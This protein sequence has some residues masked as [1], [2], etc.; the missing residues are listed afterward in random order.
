MKDAKVIVLE[1]T[2]GVSLTKCKLKIGEKLYIVKTVG[3]PWNNP[4]DYIE[5]SRSIGGQ[6]VFNFKPKDLKL[7]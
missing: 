1:K 2:Y 3:D 4:G 7:A 5:A 6:H